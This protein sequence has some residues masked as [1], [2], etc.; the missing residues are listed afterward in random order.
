MT[1]ISRSALFGRLNPAGLKSI[2]TATG[3]CK[4]RGNPYVELVH[5]IHILLQDPRN[6]V[7]AIRARFQLDDAKLARD[8]VAALDA[9]PRGATAISD[10]SPQIEE[11]V[12]KGWLYASLMF[13][14]SRVRTGQL[15]FGVLKTQTLKNALYSISPEWRK[16]QIELLGD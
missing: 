15:I 8:V 14:A 12:E 7:A 10:F 3:F 16:V 5:W 4:M 6:D 11:A 1:E 2:E 9:L 13:G